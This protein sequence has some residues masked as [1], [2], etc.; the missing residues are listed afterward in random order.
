VGVRECG[1]CAHVAGLL[2]ARLRRALCR[3]ARRLPSLQCNLARPCSRQQEGA[4]AGAQS[5]ADRPVGQLSLGEYLATARRLCLCR[6]GDWA[7]KLERK[8]SP[9]PPPPPPPRPLPPGG[10]GQSQ[11]AN[12]GQAATSAN[13]VAG[14]EQ[15]MVY[16][17][18]SH[19]HRDGESGR[20]KSVMYGWMPW[21]KKEVSLCVCVSVCV[22]VCKICMCVYV[23]L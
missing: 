19:A 23:C 3:A 6:Q 17:V 16:A 13:A 4:G 11:D 15:D 1:V 7:V 21:K 8:G 14:R 12:E 20:G 10:A 9:P 5:W 18:G 2:A 22:C